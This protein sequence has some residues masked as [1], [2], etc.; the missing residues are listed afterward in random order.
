MLSRLREL[1]RGDQRPSG[2]TVR[3]WEH[4]TLDDNNQLIRVRTVRVDIDRDHRLQATWPITQTRTDKGEPSCSDS[5]G[6]SGSR[7]PQRW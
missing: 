7:S 3:D 6:S 1:L 4:D 5:T 2:I